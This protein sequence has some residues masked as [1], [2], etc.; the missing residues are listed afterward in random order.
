MYFCIVLEVVILAGEMLVL[1]R[2]R[3]GLSRDILNSV[4]HRRVNGIFHSHR[5]TVMRGSHARL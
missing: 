4:V 5:I 2:T 3:V 1:R